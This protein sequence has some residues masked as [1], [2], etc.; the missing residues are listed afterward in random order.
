M[1]TQ[2]ATRSPIIMAVALVLARVTWGMMDESATHRPLTPRT[3]HCWS[4]TAIASP[5]GPMRQVPETWRELPS[6][7]RIQLS[8]SS[9]LP[10]IS[11][12]GAIRPS[13]MPLVCVGLQDAACQLHS[14]AHPAHIV[15]IVEVA[16]VDGGLDRGIR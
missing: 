3:R 14:L 13:D 2:S 12:V 5:S 6:V 16:V 11:S 10:R 15:F 1:A 9:S 4:V 7:W 8:S